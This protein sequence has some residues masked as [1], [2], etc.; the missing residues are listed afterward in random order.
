MDSSGTT[1]VSSFASDEF[2]RQTAVTG[3][4]AHTFTG[5]LGVRNEVGIDSQLL[6]A[7][8]RW[9]DPQLGRFLNEDPIG[10]A[11]GLNLYS[12][13]ANNPVNGVDPEG[14]HPWGRTGG[15]WRFTQSEDSWYASLSKFANFL[16]GTPMMTEYGPETEATKA[17]QTD[18][19]RINR[20]IEDWIKRNKAARAKDPNCPLQS[21]KFYPEDGVG[22]E[23]WGLNG[24]PLQAGTNPTLHFVGGYGIKFTPEGDQLKVE[25]INK[26]SLK[27]LFYDLIP[28]SHDVKWL[29]GHTQT[30]TYRWQVQRPRL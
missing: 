30:Q 1:V 27:S 19:E 16:S 26:T 21:T 7:R 12:Y 29:P 25:V 24:G 17:M 8:Q 6:Y 3:S 13:V 2:G 28:V 14:L 5:A 22:M 18:R 9:Y 15:G 4:P 11:G 20:G 10:F 23:N